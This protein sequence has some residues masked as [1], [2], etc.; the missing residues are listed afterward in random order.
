MPELSRTATDSEHLLES[1]LGR[2]ADEYADRLKHGE[3]PDIESY[4]SRYPQI[5]GTLRRV[6]P[7]IEVMC[8]L[9]EAD[10]S[11]TGEVVPHALGDYR[12]LEE[13]G[14]GG[15][16]VVYRAEQLSL[17][18]DV[19]L[20]VLPFASLL[21]PR[22]LQRFRN[23]AMAAAQLDHPHIVSVFG[24]G[25]E[26][27]VHYYAMQLVEGQTLADVIESRRSPPANPAGPDDDTK[28]VAKPSTVNTVDDHEWFRT[29]AAI[30]V[31]VAEALEYAHSLG[32][33]HRDI[34]P[35]N[36][37]IDRAGQV[38]ITDF[39]LA[40]IESDAGLT[41]TGDVLGTLRY[42]S[43]EQAAGRPGMVDL[44]T[45]V[46]SLGV[47][48]YELLT[49]RPAV[50]G[51]QRAELL[52]SL[53][54]DEPRPLRNH[55]RAIPV[56]LETIVLKACARIATER[57]QSAAELADDLQRFLDHRPIRAR[58]T[59]LW[60][61][62]RKWSRRNRP[63][64]IAASVVMAA[65]ITGG[66]T[67]AVLLHQERMRTRFERERA[68]T[69]EELA[70][71]RARLYQTQRRMAQAAEDNSRLN[72]YVT[73]IQLAD[74]AWQ[75]GELDEAMAELQQCI[76]QAGETDLRGFEWHY[77]WR[78][79]SHTQPVWGQH[80][81]E[82][83]DVRISPDGKLVAS[84]GQ[85][86]V[87]IW[88]A[89]TGA[90]QAHLTS[91]SLDVNAVSFSPDGNL[92]ATASDDD[93]VG[94]WSTG[95]WNLLQLLPHDSTVVG[96]VFIPNSSLLA[97]AERVHHPYPSPKRGRNVVRIWDTID[98]QIVSE[99]TPLPST[100]N[101]LR[102]NDDGTLLAT[103]TSDSLTQVWDIATS[104][105]RHSLPPPA[106]FGSSAND[107]TFAHH[108]PWLAV[109]YNSGAVRIWHL[110]TWKMLAELPDHIP[111]RVDSVDFD[112]L[113]DMLVTAS[114][115]SVIH[116][117]TLGPAASPLSVHAFQG[118]NDFWR[119][120]RQ[121]EDWLLSA[122]RDGQLNRWRIMEPPGLRRLRLTE[123]GNSG[124][125]PPTRVAFVGPTS[126]TVTGQQVLPHIEEVTPTLQQLAIYVPYDGVGARIIDLALSPDG[127]TLA[128][129]VN[130]N[131]LVLYD[132]A[133]FNPLHAA[134]HGRY[135]QFSN[136]DGISGVAFSRDGRSIAVW[137]VPLAGWIC[138]DLVVLRETTATPLK[139]LKDTVHWQSET[140]E[141]AHPSISPD[142]SHRAVGRPSGGAV[143]IANDP[144]EHQLVLNA[145]DPFEFFAYSNDGRT[146]A[147][148]GQLYTDADTTRNGVTLWNTATGRELLT[149]PASGHHPHNLVF[150]P[151]GRILASGGHDYENRGEILIWDA[152][153]PGDG[154]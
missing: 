123:P 25:C 82:A 41:M 133:H 135:I 116:A 118:H 122:S 56:E 4:V 128:A 78:C 38:S 42:M 81:G 104:A 37:L 7:T 153:D 96:A 14:R 140:F 87:R 47:T 50:E 67:A 103:C 77:L 147:G 17:R 94:V 101:S 99:F 24:T 132:A 93:T 48:L 62:V 63:W 74:A 30:G 97:T 43:P 121:D 88:D 142:G 107:L 149:L 130:S 86:G 111:D 5:A 29:V 33:V 20:K 59:S 124:P 70:T 100:I 117:W 9:S 102:V 79:S 146:L 115:K 75:R 127:S 73:R 66:T 90:Q 120:I 113:T 125:P 80:E 150:S 143:I 98:F 39:G 137:S 134:W 49:G 13:I 108:H 69:Q 15:M 89:S 129:L 61:K 91:H 51:E 22:Q 3:Q 145:T 36:L 64:V 26:R 84:C 19:A 154:G 58:R 12:I 34:K 95:T 52:E 54:R 112:R 11:V 10:A 8:G 35:S 110:G 141:N 65:L 119:A 138:F 57:Y 1:Q 106:T 131:R 139:D 44:R 68:D 21:D 83:Y 40:Q 27:G 18:R 23:E 55:D 109:G 85:D 152:R 136:E 28:P 144:E 76:P 53:G 71:T 126:L 151:D 148:A 32:I 114:R 46:Y 6:L 2:I 31:Q 92:L 105:L 45:D 72:V 60:M 16:G